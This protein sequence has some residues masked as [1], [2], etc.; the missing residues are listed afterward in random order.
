MFGIGM[1]EL[2]VIIVVALVLLGP[3]RLPEVARSL[4]KGLAEF[5][6]LTGDVNKELDAARHM[7]E[8]EARDHERIRRE[9]ERNARKPATTQA[10]PTPVPGITAAEPDATAT[11]PEPHA[12]DPEPDAPDPKLA[13]PAPGVET[14]PSSPSG[15]HDR[16]A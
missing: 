13:A 3:K 6:R 1:P 8:S 16:D 4:G 12:P 15:K 2:A 11:D 10:E 14:T 7:I 9:T 5:R